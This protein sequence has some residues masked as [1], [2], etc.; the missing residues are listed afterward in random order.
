MEIFEP[1]PPEGQSIEVASPRYKS[2]NNNSYTEIH[3]IW[4]RYTA[5]EET[6]LQLVITQGIP[7]TALGPATS[8]GSH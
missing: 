8:R 3:E 2:L 5:W 1:L 4:R 7:F 6:G